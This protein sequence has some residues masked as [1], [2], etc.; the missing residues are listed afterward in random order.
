MNKKFYQTLLLVLL[1]FAS[2]IALATHNRAGQITYRQLGTLKYEFTLTVFTE[3]GQGQ[4]DRP[5][6]QLFFGDGTNATVK[7]KE[8]FQFP[9]TDI[10]RNTYIFEHFFPVFGNYII[11]YRDENRNAQVINFANSLQTPFYIETFLVINPQI[12]FNTSSPV[13]LADPIDFGAVGELFLHNPNGFDVDGDSLSYSLV[14]CKQEVGVEVDGYRF[15]NNSDFSSVSFTI[16]NKTGEIIW[17]TPKLIGLFN[18]AIRV[19]EYRNGT[20]IGY[21]IRDMQLVIR[22]TVNVP[23]VI[24]EIID[25]CIVAGSTLF[26]KVTAN[27]QNTSSPRNDRILL[28]AGGGPFEVNP[29][30]TFIS[31]TGDGSV[32]SNFSWTTNCDLA[33]KQPYQVVFRAEDNGDPKLVDLETY[34][35]T[36]VAPAPENLQTA[37]VG[38]TINLSWN[39]SVC[40]KAAGYKIYRRKGFINFTPTGCLT[41]VPDFLG[42][43]LIETVPNINTLN[44]T[45]NNA[46]NGGLA[47]GVNYCYRIIAYFNDGTESYASE[48]SCSQLEKTLAVLTNVTIVTT[49]ISIGTDT[50]RWSKP[51]VFDTLQISPP[52]EY[53][54]LRSESTN[55]G[56][57]TE[58]FSQ[59]SPT[60]GGLNDTIFLDAGLNTLDKQY[61]YIVDMYGV[62]TNGRYLLGSSQRAKSIFLKITPLDNKLKLDWEVDVPWQNIEY[63]IFKKNTSGQFD[64]IG[65]SRSTTYTDKNL[66][67]GKEYCYFIKSRGSFFIPGFI[68]PVINLSQK[69]CSRPEDVEKPCSPILS[70]QSGCDSA[71]IGSSNRLTWTLPDLNCNEDI[72]AYNIFKQSFQDK[73]FELLVRIEPGSQLTFTDANLLESIAACYYIIA[74]DSNDKNKSDKSNVVCVDNCPKFVLPNVFTPNN[75]GIN[76]FFVPFPDS[77]GYNQTINI[78][79]F[80]RWGQQVYKTNKVNIEWDGLDNSGKKVSEGVYFYVCDITELRFAGTRKRVLKGIIHVLY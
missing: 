24:D 52:Y 47:I 69:A 25:T 49:D 29:G 71:N 28:T 68:E 59:I 35:I 5:E 42:Y 66:L 6:A 26:L 61:T 79:I 18:I 14:A 7:R 76:D 21:L 40:S 55:P 16:N 64:S 33:R 56:V 44:F 41:G 57:F 36:I 54:L 70:V 4:A 23:P 77:A 39:K 13:L 74:I 37:P 60:F 75:D 51:I 20:L 53:R 78:I 30:A 19:E 67:N 11:S 73:D 3:V 1:L 46:A 43:E 10:A 15:L 27:D 62:G 12:G 31:K 50:V 2:S 80:N 65:V 22:S 38:N 8:K 34:L 48:E 63:A 17:N 45:D 72:I 32:S 58:V 9:G